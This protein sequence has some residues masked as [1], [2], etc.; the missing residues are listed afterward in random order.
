VK[1]TVNI[2]LDDHAI[3][4]L[5]Q[6]HGI[7]RL[8]DKYGRERSQCGCKRANY[9]GDPG[10]RTVKN[11]LEKGLDRVANVEPFPVK[12]GAYLRGPEELLLS[13]SGKEGV[14]A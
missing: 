9:F 2:L 1:K 4:H 6:V 7:L 12:T 11:I 10:F 8:K 14:K 5:R 3:Y 13:F